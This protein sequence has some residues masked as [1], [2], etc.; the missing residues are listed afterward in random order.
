MQ[1]IRGSDFARSCLP[2]L[3][4]SV[5][6]SACH[7][8]VEVEP[9]QMALQEQADKPV[10]ARNELRLHV[11]EEGETFEG[12]PIHIFGADSVVLAKGAGRVTVATQEVT[13]VDVRRTDTAATLGL[14]AAIAA[15]S[16]VAIAYISFLATVDFE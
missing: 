11:G 7:K 6:L 16:I 5:C 12:D 2:L 4:L 3:A 1:W 14:T 15:V 8:W 13:R 9:P 10:Q